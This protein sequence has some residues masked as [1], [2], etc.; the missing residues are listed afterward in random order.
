M[1]MAVVA[2][3]VVLSLLLILIIIVQPGKGG[4]VGAA[5][6]GG[7]GSNLFGPRGP[8]SLL[9]RGTTFVAVMFMV[10]SITLAWFSNKEI[11][12]NSNVLDELDRVGRA[13]QAPGDDAAEP[14]TPEAVDPDGGEVIEI[15]PI[16]APAAEEPAEE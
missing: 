8:T 6:G 13:R 15:T 5:F 16:E 7:G 11:L 2:T 12:A 14:E 4:D 10:T 9:Q 3:H 1:Y